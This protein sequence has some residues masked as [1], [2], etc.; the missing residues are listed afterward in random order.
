MSAANPPR[1]SS[2][3]RRWNRLDR[4]EQVV[5]TV[6]ASREYSLQRFSRIH[7]RSINSLLY[8]YVVNILIFAHRHEFYVFSR[9]RLLSKQLIKQLKEKA[10]SQSL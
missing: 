4:S 1:K 7:F 10:P 3:F 2:R 9:L 5:L 6:L 8:V